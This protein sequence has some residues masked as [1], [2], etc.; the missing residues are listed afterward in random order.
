MKGIRKTIVIAAAVLAAGALS[1]C[2]VLS[3]KEATACPQYVVASDAASVTRFR[4]GPGRDLTDVVNQGEINGVLLVA[5]AIYF[6]VRSH[7]V[8]EI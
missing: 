4:E 7:G 6:L 3:K 1:G 8:R 2:G 5:V